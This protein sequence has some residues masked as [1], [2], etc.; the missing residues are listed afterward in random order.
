MKM[1][2]NSEQTAKLIELGLEKPTGWSAEGISSW[3]VMYKH[4]DNDE[5]FNYSIGELIEMLPPIIVWKR[6]NLAS[7]IARTT[8]NSFVS[9]AELGGTPH[10]VEKSTELIDALYDMIIKLKEESVI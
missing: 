4:K 9:Y 6:K 10:I 1:Y 2:T 8:F 5:D 7:T 3:F